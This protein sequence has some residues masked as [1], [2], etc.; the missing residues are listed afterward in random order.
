MSKTYHDIQ[1]LRAVAAALVVISHAVILFHPDADRAAAGYVGYIGVCTFFVISGFVMVVSSES[2]AGTHDAI[3]F[4]VKRLIRVVPIYWTSTFLLAILKFRSGDLHIGD[5]KHLILS[6]FFIPSPLTAHGPV[7][8]FHN[9]GWTLEL[10]MMFYVV[11]SLAIWLARGRVRFVNSA[12]ILIVVCGALIRSP[13]DMS[14]ANTVAGFFTQP[15]ILLF[16][17][18]AAIGSTRLR[19][20]KNQSSSFLYV[21]VLLISLASIWFVFTRGEYPFSI[22][23]TACA[24]AVAA[25]SV[26]TCTERYAVA[27]ARAL[28]DLFR[29]CGDAS[30][31][32]YMFHIFFVTIFVGV[33]KSML[34]DHY[35]I[36]F[37]A[38][39]LIASFTISIGI[40]RTIEY[41][42]T[43]YLRRLLSAGPRIKRPDYSSV[44]SECTSS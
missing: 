29:R 16:G 10:E 35:L 13:F 26:W 12:L 25:L 8:P 11:Y 1:S 33:W 41:P 44:P 18:G 4:S 36:A 28:Q 17:L 43:A 21:P 30:Y 24:W 37:V 2:E 3:R 38:F 5:V 32:V 9:Q 42:I 19:W 34:G 39:F 27:S 20:R 22:L 6:V 23:S 7:R 14:D 31:S 15:V 40:Y